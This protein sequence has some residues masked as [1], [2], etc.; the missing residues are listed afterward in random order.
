MSETNRLRPATIVLVIASLVS[1]ISINA[2]PAPAA[3]PD[4]VLQWVGITNDA[5]RDGWNCA[6]TAAIS[7]GIGNR[8]VP[9]RRWCLATDAI[10]ECLGRGP[11]IRHHDTLG[12]GTCIT[13]PFTA[14]A[15]AHQR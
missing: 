7:G 1:F 8:N 2:T 10:A 5:V 15:S 9:R 6:T 12:H 14:A 3:V 4:P 13:I 11:A